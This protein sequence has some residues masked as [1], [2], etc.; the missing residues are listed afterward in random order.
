M[1]IPMP[2]ST[3]DTGDAFSKKDGAAGHRI[4]EGGTGI[5]DTRSYVQIVCQPS[6]GV[7]FQSEA[8]QSAWQTWVTSNLFVNSNKDH[9]MATHDTDRDGSEQSTNSS[10]DANEDREW[11]SPGK[12]FSAIDPNQSI[13][14]C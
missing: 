10:S 4:T 13:V 2:S 7:L 1:R 14:W 11:R 9:D 3:Q 6:D 5:E 12:L 8:F